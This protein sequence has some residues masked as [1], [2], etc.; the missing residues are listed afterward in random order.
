[1]ARG[2]N[3]HEEIRLSRVWAVD[4]LRLPRGCAPTKEDKWS[5]LKGIKFPRI[6]SD[7]VSLLIG[8]DVP[9]AHWV[10]DQRR[11]RRG[12]PYAVCTHLG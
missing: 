1:M 3:L 8:C 11:G 12:Q 6:Q 10:N 4:P 5:H 9:E 7:E 2:I